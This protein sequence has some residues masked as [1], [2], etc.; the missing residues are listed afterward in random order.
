MINL[1][2]YNEMLKLLISYDNKLITQQ[3]FEERKQELLEMERIQK[4]EMNQGDSLVPSFTQSDFIREKRSL[5]AKRYFVLFFIMLFLGGGAGMAFVKWREYVAKPPIVSPDP[6]PIE[7]ELNP[8]SYEISELIGSTS[9][10]L[11]QKFPS[12]LLAE[13]ESIS[14]ADGSTNNFTLY[15]AWAED[16]K[17]KFTFYFYQDELVRVVLDAQ[18]R[19]LFSGAKATAADYGIALTEAAWPYESGHESIVYQRVDENIEEMAFLKILDDKSYERA[20]FT[21]KQELFGPLTV[22]NPDLYW[23]GA[24]TIVKAAL[25]RPDSAVFP[26]EH[27]NYRVVA[28]LGMVLVESEVEYRNAKDELTTS[29]FTVRFF[30]DLVEEANALIMDGEVLYDWS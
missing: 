11:E 16:E 19:W 15:E 6:L 12:Y 7:R 22:E 28:Y 4:A 29:V 27:Q 23:Q 2:T 26:S 1:N 5:M 30:P 3:E 25:S 24:K 13:A 8:Y 20:I 18:A 9:E 10:E 21:F 14:F 17:A